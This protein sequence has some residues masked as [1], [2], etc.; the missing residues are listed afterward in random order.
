[1]KRCLDI[2]KS[3][4]PDTQR[5]KNK[6]HLLFEDYLYS[7]KDHNW[8]FDKSKNDIINL[9]KDYSLFR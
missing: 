2:L 3:K 5:M 7:D 9:F 1:M 8:L 4:L 6:T